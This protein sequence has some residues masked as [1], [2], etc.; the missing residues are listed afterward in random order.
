MV[1]GLQPRHL[2]GQVPGAPRPAAAAEW[3]ARGSTRALRQPRPLG[4]SPATAGGR[5]LRLTWRRP[6]PARRGCAAPV[7][8]RPQAYSRRWR[9]W[10][11]RRVSRALL[12]KGRRS[13]G[14]GRGR[15]G[16]GR[17][18]GLW[19]RAPDC[20]AFGKTSSWAGFSDFAEGGPIPPQCNPGKAGSGVCE[21]LARRICSGAVYPSSLRGGISDPSL[22]V[23]GA[24]AL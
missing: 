24:K 7:P 21:Q 14:T 19:A 22:C 20:S 1:F 9:R 18:R 17:L 8:A 2:I 5:P 11:S 15:T 16:Q 23:E 6:G 10:T 13:T 12:P 4:G 3:S